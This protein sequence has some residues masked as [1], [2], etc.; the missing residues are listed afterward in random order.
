MSWSITPVGCH[1]HHHGQGYT[2]SRLSGLSKSWMGKM[3]RALRLSQLCSL[4]GHTTRSEGS[5][6]CPL[7]RHLCPHQSHDSQIY[8]HCNL[9]LEKCS[10]S[11]TPELMNKVCFRADASKKAWLSAAQQFF[12]NWL[13]LRSFKWSGQPSPMTFQN[14]SLHTCPVKIQSEGLYCSQVIESCC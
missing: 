10:C 11:A 1:N 5:C 14:I 12:L 6:Q 2:G 13:H 8:N 4:E 7:P 3:R 9:C